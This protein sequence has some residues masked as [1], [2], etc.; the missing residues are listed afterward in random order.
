MATLPGGNVGMSGG[1][2]HAIPRKASDRNEGN[3]RTP[4]GSQRCGCREV[5]TAHV[6]GRRALMLRLIKPTLAPKPQRA[7]AAWQSWE[8]T[9]TQ[10]FQNRAP[11][12]T[13]LRK[14]KNVARARNF[15]PFFTI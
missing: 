13:R 1:L 11:L 10:R 9:A 15:T 6:Q 12:S 8:R 5:V 2:A 3:V 7:H 14:V 4:Q